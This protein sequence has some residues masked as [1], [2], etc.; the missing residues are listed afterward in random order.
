M[1]RYLAYTGATLDTTIYFGWQGTFDVYVRSVNVLNLDSMACE[2][3][4]NVGRDYYYERGLCQQVVSEWTGPIS[5]DAYITPTGRRPLITVDAEISTERV[6]IFFR[7]FR[8][9]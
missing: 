5:M 1:D 9:Q 8:I 6:P 2:N 3:Q 7:S 4:L